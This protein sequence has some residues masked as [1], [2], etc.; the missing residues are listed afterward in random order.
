MLVDQG[1]D[2]TQADMALRIE[3]LKRGDTLAMEIARLAIEAW[4]AG[5]LSEADLAHF[6]QQDGITQQEQTYL[7]ILKDFKSLAKRKQFSIAQAETMV[8]KGLWDLSRFQGWATIEGYTPDDERD[9]ELLLFGEIKDAADAKAKRDAQTKARAQAAADKLAATQAKALAAAAVAA[10][11]G[12]SV[13]KFETLVKD[14][15]TTADQYRTS[16]I[17]KRIHSSNPD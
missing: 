14:G 5:S 9:L 16:L 13:P 8:K 4:V 1:Y 15:I 11:H 12:V 3:Y 6:I 17:S 2:S 10:S 7:G